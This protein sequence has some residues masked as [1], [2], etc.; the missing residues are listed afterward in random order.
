[1]EMKITLSQSV[2]MLL[3]GWFLAE[4]GLLEDGGAK[5]V[6]RAIG[7]RKFHKSGPDCGKEVDDYLISKGRR[8]N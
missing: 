6:G 3:G 4:V 2:R 8:E 7:C 5:V 1:M